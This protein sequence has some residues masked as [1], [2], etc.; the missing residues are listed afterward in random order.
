ME[1]VGICY[2]SVLNDAGSHGLESRQCV[3]KGDR[4]GKTAANFRATR[5]VLCIFHGKVD[6][7]DAH[8]EL[9]RNVPT[10][11]NNET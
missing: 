1:R 11:G 3:L 6:C 4:D 5:F 9:F 7:Q 8:C 2:H 10:R